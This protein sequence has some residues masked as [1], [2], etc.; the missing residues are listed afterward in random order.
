MGQLYRS[1]VQEYSTVWD[2]TSDLS[3]PHVAT[4]PSSLGTDYSS[5]TS[6]YPMVLSHGVSTTETIVYQPIKRMFTTLFQHKI[7]VIQC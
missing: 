1:Y 5:S 7:I 4:S 2:A 3:H 6:H